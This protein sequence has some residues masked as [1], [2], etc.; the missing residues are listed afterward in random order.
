[1]CRSWI[2]SSELRMEKRAT[3]CDPKRLGAKGSVCSASSDDKLVWLK[4]FASMQQ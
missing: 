4:L 2:P 1:M 3:E